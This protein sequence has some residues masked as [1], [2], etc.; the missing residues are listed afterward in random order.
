[1]QLFATSRQHLGLYVV[2]FRAT[3]LILSARCLN[4]LWPSPSSASSSPTSEIFRY[5]THTA[6]VEVHFWLVCYIYWP[7]GVNSAQKMLHSDKGRPPALQETFF[8]SVIKK[9]SSDWT[10]NTF[11]WASQIPWKLGKSRRAVR[12]SLCVASFC[13]VKKINLRAEAHLQSSHLY[14]R[15][16]SGIAASHHHKREASESSPLLAGGTWPAAEHP[17]KNCFYS[18]VSGFFYMVF[19]FKLVWWH[20]VSAPKYILSSLRCI[21]METEPLKTW[22]IQPKLS[23]DCRDNRRGGRG[24]FLIFLWFVKLTL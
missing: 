19:F 15:P 20:R 8:H 23:P 2:S 1:M 14:N 3:R 4:G 21:R 13:F 10:A 7:S 11:F 12:L 6:A 16:H 9:R 18:D 17:A 5:S 22:L 24:I